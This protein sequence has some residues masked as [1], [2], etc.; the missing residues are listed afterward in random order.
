MLAVVRVGLGANDTCLVAW[1]D[2]VANIDALDLAR[3][4]ADTHVK[5]H[6]C[7]E[8]QEPSPLGKFVNDNR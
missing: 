1:V 6:I 4:Y 8:G 3:K 2:A 5:S 7:H